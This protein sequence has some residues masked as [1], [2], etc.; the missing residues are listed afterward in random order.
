[1]RDGYLRNFVPFILADTDIGSKNSYR[2][3]DSS[4]DE[5][6]GTQMLVDSIHL[7][8]EIAAEHCADFES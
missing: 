4:D 2:E 5:L 1:M 8:A 3:K 6:Y 7:Y